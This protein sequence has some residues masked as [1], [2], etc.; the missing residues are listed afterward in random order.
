MAT[1]CLIVGTRGFP[2]NPYENDLFAKQLEQTA[3]LVG[4]KRD[5]VIIDLGHRG[6]G[7]ATMLGVE[8]V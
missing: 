6:Y 8:S 4:R 2:G 7:K 5:I 1:R 3:I